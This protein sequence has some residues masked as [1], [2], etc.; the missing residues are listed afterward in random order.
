ML[1]E[2]LVLIVFLVRG[3]MPHFWALIIGIRVVNV[4]ASMHP[5]ILEKMYSVDWW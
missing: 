1:L 4:E 2:N 3:L 5:I